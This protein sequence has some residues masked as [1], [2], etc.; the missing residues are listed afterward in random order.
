MKER[1][2]RREKFLEGKS[3]N[4]TDNTHENIETD[5]SSDKETIATSDDAQI[6]KSEKPQT[7]VI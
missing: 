3:V 1:N 5:L 2:F 7:E 4:S 6:Q